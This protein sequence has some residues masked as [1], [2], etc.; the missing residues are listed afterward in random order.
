VAWIVDVFAH[1][2]KWVALAAVAALAIWLFWIRRKK[3]SQRL[4]ANENEATIR[5]RSEQN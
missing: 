2:F 4:A 5:L 3:A 1:H